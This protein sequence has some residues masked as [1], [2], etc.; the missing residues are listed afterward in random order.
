MVNAPNGPRGSYGGGL[1]LKEG[2]ADRASVGGSEGVWVTSMKDRSAALPRRRRFRPRF[3]SFTI[4]PH[5]AHSKTF[6][7]KEWRSSKRRRPI[8]MVRAARSRA[9]FLA[10]PPSP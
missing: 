10:R 1:V 7:E 5:P 8:S 4:S 9:Y 6:F 3:P 2:G